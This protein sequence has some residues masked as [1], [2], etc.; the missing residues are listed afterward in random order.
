MKIKLLRKR[1]YILIFLFLGIE[2]SAYPITSSQFEQPVKWKVGQSK[3]Q[4]EKSNNIYEITCTADISG[5]WHTYDFGPYN[6][7][8]NPTLLQIKGEG[9]KLIGKPYVKR[10]RVKEYDS[11][12]GMDVGILGNGAVIAQKV[13]VSSPNSQKVEVNVEWQACTSGSCLPPAEESY[14][15]TLPAATEENNSEREKIAEETAN[16]DDAKSIDVASEDTKTAEEGEKDT[17]SDFTPIQTKNRSIWSFILEAIGWGFLALLTPCVFPMIPMTVS[18]FLKQNENHPTKG[19]IMAIIYGICIVMIYTIPIAI[20]ILLTY[21]LGGGSVT[22]DIFNWLSTNWIPNI[23]FFIIF[24]L[25]ALSFFGAFEITMPSKL[26]NKADSKSSKGGWIGVFF[27]ALTLVLVSFSCTGPIVG[28]ALIKSTQGEIWTPI[29]VML[30]FSI[31]FAIPFTIFAFAPSLIKNLKSGGWLNSVKVVLGFLELA[32]GMKFLSVADQTYH[33]GILDREIYL[34]FWIVIFS[35]M[36]IY[37]LG[38]IKFKYDSPMEHLPVGRLILSIIVF[39]FVVYMIPG[40]WGAPLK[41]L[42]G[43]LPPIQSQDFVVNYNS[44]SHIDSPNA[45]SGTLILKENEIVAK[46]SD[47]LQ[48]PHG[49]KGYFTYNEALEASKRENKPIFLDFT[50]HGCVNCREMEARVWSNPDV[51]KLLREEFILCSLYAD[52][53]MTVNEEDFV[54]LPNGKVLKDMGKINSRFILDKFNVNAQP[55]YILLDSEGNQLV[56]PTGY[57]LN[58]EEYKKFLQSGID[59]F[60]GK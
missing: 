34:A 22:A 44:G 4:D 42:S 59:A 12:F 53:K 9:V 58:I 23:I 57:N 13:E 38:K 33:W 47:K 46:Y 26:V 8:P 43:Y 37:L 28:T 17:I 51:L 1:F 30:V 14:S 21:T 19:K 55:F 45:T 24:I 7:G 25:F 54:T 20:L 18:F 27:M 32:L 29:I 10:G 48:L 49:L 39:A 16:I 31:V 56:P 3:V 52:D 40:M 5:D 6:E 36:G 50:G 60:R 2:V 35:L 41:A 15:I 11:A